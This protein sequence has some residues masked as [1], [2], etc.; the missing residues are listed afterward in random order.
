MRLLYLPVKERRVDWNPSDEL[1]RALRKDTIL[2]SV[3]AANNETGVLQPIREIVV[4]CRER[5]IIF[6]TDAAQALGK[7]PINVSA[8]NIDLSFSISLV[9]KGLRPG[10]K[11]VGALYVRKSAEVKLAPQIR[12][13]R[14]RAWTALGNAECSGNRWIGE[15][16]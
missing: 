2:V 1:M 14:A 7:T 9:T 8:D 3:M 15:S 16:L 12:R 6:H 11:G 13:R 10:P 5:G 4:L